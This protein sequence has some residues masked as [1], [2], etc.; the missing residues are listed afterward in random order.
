MTRFD[1]TDLTQLWVTTGL[2]LTEDKTMN[3]F[4]FQIFVLDTP[5]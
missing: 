3:S 5:V 4:M 1:D 2:L